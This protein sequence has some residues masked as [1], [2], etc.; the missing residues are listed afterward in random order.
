MISAVGGLGRHLELVGQLFPLHDQRVVA[1]DLELLGQALEHAFVR[2]AD[3]RQLAV[4]RL[5]RADH[6][7]AED[8]ADRLM[9][10]A[11]AEQRH[12]PAAAFPISS[13]QMPA[14][15]GVHGPGDS[16]IASG[17]GLQHLVGA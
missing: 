16:T 3:G 10:E 7:A 8:L 9:A 2:V 6:L 1:R 5:G 14:S 11:N 4:H 17:L 15:F 13:R 12:L